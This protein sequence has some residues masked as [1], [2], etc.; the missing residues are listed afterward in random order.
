[1]VTKKKYKQITSVHGSNVLTVKANRVFN[2]NLAL[3][4]LHVVFREFPRFLRLINSICS[5]K[6]FC[7]QFFKGSLFQ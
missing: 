6:C 7:V 5:V 2:L 4:N 3:G 1:M